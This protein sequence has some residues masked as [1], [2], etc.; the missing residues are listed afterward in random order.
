MTEKE[1]KVLINQ[2]DY[3][4]LLGSFGFNKNYRQVN[5]YFDTK[6]NYCKL[7]NI[8]I[9]IREK[10]N[11]CCLQV[12]VP[13]KYDN[14]LH[15]KKEYEKKYSFLKTQITSDELKI[16]TGLDIPTV[17]CIGMLA[18]QRNEYIVN[19]TIL[20]LD[21]NEYNGVTDYELEVEFQNQVDENV[22]QVLNETGL[23]FEKTVDGKFSRFCKTL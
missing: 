6:D 18:T 7:N 23:S 21:K 11:K 16:L 9:R 15:I 22:M 10:E 12:K 17:N 5:Y 2:D 19:D 8:T 13:I 14:A 3:K 20:C 1:Y 4:E